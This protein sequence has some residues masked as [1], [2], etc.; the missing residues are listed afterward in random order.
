MKTHTFAICAYGQPEYLEEC[1]SS[2]V[3]Q[4]VKSEIIICT[5]TPNDAIDLIAEKYDI[6]VVV[7]TGEKGITQDWNFA[8]SNI[9]TK[10]GTIAHQDDIYKSCYT[11][12]MLD[13]MEKSKNP[14]IGFCDYG[15]I[16]GDCKIDSTGMLK[17]KK[18]MLL[19]LRLR[20]LWQSRFIRRAILSFGDPICC[21]SVMFCMNSVTLPVF[22][23]H[24]RSCEDWEAWEH[25]SKNKGSY[26]YVARPMM[27]HRIHAESETSKII[28]D[29]ARVSENYE[30]FCKF[31]PAPIARVLNRI[32][33][34]SENYNQI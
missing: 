20:C 1:V 26:V 29:G 30:M 25:L 34:K 7:N 13:A 3:K 14:L 33:T 32:Y 19:P 23:N 27:Y 2:L 18:I 17:I 5:S 12:F 6:D 4:T 16:H 21:P 15:E 8:L 10:Y 11:E 31:W 28:N 9:R 22:R 24:F